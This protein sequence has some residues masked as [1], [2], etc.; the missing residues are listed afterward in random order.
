MPLLCTESGAVRHTTH[1]LCVSRGKISDDSLLETLFPPFSPH[2]SPSQ[3]PLLTDV[4]SQ[5]S[6]SSPLPRSQHLDTPTMC[7]YSSQQ[8]G[9]VTF[10]AGRGTAAAMLCICGALAAFPRPAHLSSLHPLPLLP[11]PLTPLHFITYLQTTSYHTHTHSHTLDA[12]PL[13]HF[14]TFSLPSPHT[15]EW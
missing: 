14:H 15:I 2:P 12:F 6:L 7:I 4:R 1:W 9:Q 5:H 11:C 3:R 13:A 10:I 8:Y